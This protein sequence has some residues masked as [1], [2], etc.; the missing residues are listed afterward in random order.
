MKHFAK[1][2]QF[3]TFTALMMHM[4]AMAMRGHIHT[5]ALEDPA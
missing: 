5:A 3:S 4:M 2:A 1:A